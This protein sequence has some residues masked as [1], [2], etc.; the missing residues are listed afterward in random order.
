MCRKNPEFAV[1]R[2]FARGNPHMTPA[3][4]AAYD[5]P[6]PDSGHRAALRAF[7]PMVPDRPEA[8][9]AAVSR[10]ARD[11]LS[12]HWQGR[13]LMAI[14]AQDPVLGVPVMEDLR[15]H[16]R[17]CGEPIVLPQAGHFVQEHGEAIAREAVGYFRP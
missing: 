5:A 1:G 7:P 17:G 15:R 13:T 9:G 16:I 4:C 2:L 11:F 12:R 10:Q 3:E 8:D 14:G 6:F